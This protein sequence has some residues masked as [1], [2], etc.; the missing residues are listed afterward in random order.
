MAGDGSH[1][2]SKG[3][4]VPG[5][6]AYSL[7]G[8]EDQWT[9]KGPARTKRGGKQTASGSKQDVVLQND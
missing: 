5:L 6:T 3:H 1:I 2:K 7:L 4:P 9:L 8:L